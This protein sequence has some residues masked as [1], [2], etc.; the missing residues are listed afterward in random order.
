MNFVKSNNLSL[1]Y[2]KFTPSGCNDLVIRKFKFVVKNQFK[3]KM[4]SKLI[5]S[6]F[7]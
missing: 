3:S 6:L 5:D 4:C 1:K 7:F 2:R